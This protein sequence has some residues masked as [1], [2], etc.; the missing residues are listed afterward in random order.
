MLPVAR[1]PA[2]IATYIMLE[3][4]RDA[5]NPHSGRKSP[6]GLKN[7]GTGKKAKKGGDKPAE[8]NAKPSDVLG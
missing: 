5:G 6:F 7:T 2:S 1:F 4:D 3:H 8:P